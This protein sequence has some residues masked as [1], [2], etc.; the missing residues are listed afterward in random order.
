M[1]IAESPKQIHFRIGDLKLDIKITIA[2][3]I[4]TTIAIIP[5]YEKENDN[6]TITIF[7]RTAKLRKKN[8]TKAN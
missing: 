2:V 4:N 1:E 5:L 7:L 6:D 3:N 8:I